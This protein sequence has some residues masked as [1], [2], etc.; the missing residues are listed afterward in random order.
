MKL[1]KDLNENQE[2][3]FRQWA[4]DNYKPFSPIEGIWHPVVQDECAKMNAAQQFAEDPRDL[5]RPL[6]DEA[7]NPNG[8]EPVEDRIQCPWC[9]QGWLEN[10][11]AEYKDP[12]AVVYCS[13]CSSVFKLTAL[14]EVSP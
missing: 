12:A 6:D 7:F 11:P 9:K 13:D 8:P 10:T 4:R 14:P 2:A 3:E 1:F 5:Y